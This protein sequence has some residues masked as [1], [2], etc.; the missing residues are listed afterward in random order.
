VLAAVADE[1][2]EGRRALSLWEIPATLDAAG[3]QRVIEALCLC[4]GGR[5]AAPDPA[6][7]AP[8]GGSPEHAA[9]AHLLASPRVANGVRRHIHADGF[10]WAGLLAAAAT[11]SRAQRLLVDIAHDLWTRGEAVGVRELARG[12][13]TGSFVRAVEALAA[14]RRDFAAERRLL[15]VA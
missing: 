7:V 4:H 1:I 8:A 15:R 2:V 3:M 5:G 9:V 13:D 11:M 6:R 10:D 12:L 14:C